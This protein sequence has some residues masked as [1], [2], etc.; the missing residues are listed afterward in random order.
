M[1]YV[2]KGQQ[3]AD[4]IDDALG[5]VEWLYNNRDY[6]YLYESEGVSVRMVNC[7][8]ELRSL[9]LTDIDREF[10]DV[11]SDFD[12]MRA[13]KRIYE[14]KF[15]GIINWVSE[16]SGKNVGM[17][18]SKFKG[19]CRELSS[20]AKYMGSS[21]DIS[22]ARNHT[23]LLYA[24]HYVRDRIITLIQQ[25]EIISNPE[26]DCDVLVNKTKKAIVANS[27]KAISSTVNQTTGVASSTKTFDKYLLHKDNLQLA[28]ALKAQFSTEKGKAIRLLIEAMKEN[29]PPVLAIARGENNAFYEAM[30]SFFNRNIGTYPSIFDYVI[31][32]SDSDVME[33][34]KTRLNYLLEQMK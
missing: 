19:E 16:E 2:E 34:V 18:S 24:L 28:N 17:Y 8:E 29:N 25:W 30:R 20:S 9:D 4:I 13:V 12:K 7:F 27:P 1:K 14:V 26:L 6:A 11:C 32:E 5:Y 15:A 21:H 22:L 33:A 23:M 3:F 31:K 10:W